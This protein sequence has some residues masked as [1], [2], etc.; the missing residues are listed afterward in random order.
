MGILPEAWMVLAM[1]ELCTKNTGG[2]RETAAA[3]E[4][5]VQT[6]ELTEN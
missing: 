1:E 5:L 6:L 2:Q 3:H 4:I